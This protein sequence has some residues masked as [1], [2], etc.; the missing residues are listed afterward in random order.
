MMFVLL[1]SDVPYYG[2]VHV[3]EA[4][5]THKF[6]F[7][8]EY[9]SDDVCTEIGRTLIISSHQWRLYVIWPHISRLYNFKNNI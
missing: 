5:I 1:Y 3:L 9:F 7:L 2:T 8:Q 4:S 6:Q